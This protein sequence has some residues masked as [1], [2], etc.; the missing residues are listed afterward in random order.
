MRWAGLAV[1][2]LLAAPAAATHDDE[3][4]VTDYSAWTLR[5]LEFR[6]GPGRVE[7]GVIDPVDLGTLTWLWYLK[8]ANV[9]AKYRFLSGK[10]WALSA[11]L[12]VGTINAKRL[13]EGNQDAQIW[14]IPTELVGTWRTGP[15]SSNLGLGFTVTRTAADLNTDSDA[16]VAAALAVSVGYLHP[17][18]EWRL[19]P[20]FALFLESRIALFEQVAGGAETV[21]VSD[22]GRTTIEVYGDGTAGLLDGFTGNATIGG[23]WSW[24]HFNLRAGFGYGHYVVPGVNLFVTKALPYPDFSVFWRF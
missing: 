7:A 10:D 16:D 23:F 13:G 6:V 11:A 4:P 21:T 19:G 20:V 8:V 1:C 2:A 18:F 5:K 9:H 24:P 15:L 14:I 17:T 22:D 3:G 12:G